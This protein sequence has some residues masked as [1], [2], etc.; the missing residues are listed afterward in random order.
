MSQHLEG[1]HTLDAKAD[2]RVRDLDS[3][4]RGGCD[5]VGHNRVA[6]GERMRYEVVVCY[7]EERADRGGF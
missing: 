6:V 7:L 2:A 5:L 3:L 1:I 4:R